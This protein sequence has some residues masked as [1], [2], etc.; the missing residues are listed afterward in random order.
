MT[1]I[2]AGGKLLMQTWAFRK[3]VLM[4]LFYI[5]T[6]DFMVSFY[7]TIIFTIFNAVFLNQNSRF[8]I[9]TKNYR[10]DEPVQ[11]DDYVKALALVRKYE[12]ERRI[13][14]TPRKEEDDRP[15]TNEAD[16]IDRYYA[17]KVRGSA[18]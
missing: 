4:A 13:T 6:K 8:N 17:N 1:D 10:N 3:M 14:L 11:E 18:P 16:W 7:F 2:N 9:L 12:V 15:S 5:A